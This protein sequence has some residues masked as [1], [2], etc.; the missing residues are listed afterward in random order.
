[1]SA[2]LAALTTRLTVVSSS[3]IRALQP[4]RCSARLTI[5]LHFQRSQQLVNQSPAPNAIAGGLR[6]GLPAPTPSQQQRRAAASG[7]PH[8]PV[9]CA[10]SAASPISTSA[11]S[12]QFDSNIE[13]LPGLAG[14]AAPD[15]D[16]A[17]LAL[18]PWSSRQPGTNWRQI[19]DRHKQVRLPESG[20]E[21]LS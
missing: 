18:S 5:R 2:N 4:C 12:S 8:R 15:A 6:Q 11:S 21:N 7:G 10:K 19:L 3:D 9:S 17:L 13:A 16:T 14:D 20:T 1:M